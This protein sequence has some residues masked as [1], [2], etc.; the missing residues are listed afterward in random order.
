MKM[1]NRIAAAIIV[2]VYCANIAIGAD[3]MEIGPSARPI[4]MGRAYTA[5]DDTVDAILFNPAGIAGI[6]TLRFST[7]YSNLVNDYNYT[8]FAI[9]VPVKYGAVGFSMLNESS[10]A[11]YRTSLDTDGK[12]IIDPSASQFSYS[13]Q[14]FIVDYAAAYNKNLSLGSRAKLYGKGTSQVTGGYGTGTALDL[15]LVYHLNPRMNLGLSYENIL[16]SGI[17]W[18]TGTRD[19][20]PSKISAGLLFKP[21]KDLV[22]Q[23]DAVSPQ[24]RAVFLRSGAEWL[25]SDLLFLRAGVEQKEIS[26]GD[27]YF[28]YSFGVGSNF[29]NMYINYAY[30]ADTALKENSSHFIS[31]GFDIP[32]IQ[33][34]TQESRQTPPAEIQKTVSLE[35]TASVQPTQEPKSLQPAKK[36]A[37]TKTSVNVKKKIP[38]KSKIKPIKKKVLKK[39][40]AKKTLRKPAKKIK[41]TKKLIKK[42]ALPKKTKAKKTKRSMAINDLMYLSYTQ[43]GRTT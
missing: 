19:P 37:Q 29:K 2:A 41:R 8:S 10:G 24:N 34:P 17:S 18:P 28:N 11:L 13:S 16:S 39:K 38:P 12:V 25:F 6:D 4:A 36:T 7:M 1:V 35:V 5:V 30:Y 14:V 31:L 23:F 26:S 9:A 3:I 43:Q 21:R 27:R 22:L 42:K 32:G 40:I 33:Q 20:L 15:G